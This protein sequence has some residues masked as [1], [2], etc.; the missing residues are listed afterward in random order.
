[1]PKPRK[2]L[3]FSDGLP[4]RNSYEIEVEISC[5]FWEG[6]FF[7]W[8]EWMELVPS[9]PFTL[10]WVMEMIARAAA[11]RTKHER[12]RYRKIKSGFLL[13]SFR[14]QP[15]LTPP[16]LLDFFC[17]WENLIPTEITVDRCVSFKHI[18]KWWRLPWFFPIT[19]S[20]YST[21]MLGRKASFVPHWLPWAL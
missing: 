17:L 7:W 11:A 19:Y 20:Y 13:L 15:G 10:G 9:L 1:M 14:T 4:A 5:K 2:T 3:L 21:P 12:I 8:N 6:I 18:L 16:R